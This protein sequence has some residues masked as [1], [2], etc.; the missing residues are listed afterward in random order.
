[1]NE[2]RRDTVLKICVAIKIDKWR[3]FAN[4]RILEAC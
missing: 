3:R 1:M 4:D 2:W